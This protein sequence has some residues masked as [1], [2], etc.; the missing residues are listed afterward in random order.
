MDVEVR[1][2]FFGECYACSA[3]R[4][5]QYSDEPR[6]LI[7]SAFATWREFLLGERRHPGDFT[8]HLIPIDLIEFLK[9]RGHI[10]NI[11]PYRR[12]T[13]HPAIVF[14][15]IA[16]C[17]YSKLGKLLN[18]LWCDPVADSSN[19][20]VWNETKLHVN[21]GY[22]PATK[23]PTIPHMVVNYMM[24]YHTELLT[25]VSNTSPRQLENR[26][27]YYAQFRQ[28]PRIGDVQSN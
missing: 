6:H 16:L 18:A 9:L 28:S 20:R 2:C 19:G 26:R 14:D 24:H 15:G 1:V 21:N 4:Y 25:A 17:V 13:V 3:P 27:E 10:A 8:Q 23:T 22:F 12:E 11:L 5:R 7:D